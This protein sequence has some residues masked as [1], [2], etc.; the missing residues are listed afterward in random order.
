[1]IHCHDLTECFPQCLTDSLTRHISQNGL[2]FAKKLPV[3]IL[4]L[5]EKQFGE[6]I[7]LSSEA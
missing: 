6:F 4:C 3:M 2:D 5:L 1:M 7:I